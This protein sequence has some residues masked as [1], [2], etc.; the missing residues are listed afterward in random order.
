MYDTA[1]KEE[2]LDCIHLSTKALASALARGSA[3]PSIARIAILEGSALFH[4]GYI[5]S[6]RFTV[7]SSRTPQYVAAGVDLT[8]SDSHPLHYTDSLPFRPF[9]PALLAL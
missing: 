2:F 9:N 1:P 6:P 3:S 4:F 5:Y 8:H 7:K